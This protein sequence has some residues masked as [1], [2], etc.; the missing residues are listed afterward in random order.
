ME[1]IVVK[2]FIEPRLL[3]LLQ[4]QVELLKKANITRDDA[5]FHRKQV[6]NHPLLKVLHDQMA[7][8]A[9]EYFGEALKP[10]Y[11]FLSMYFEGQGACPLHVDRPQCY[12][13]IDV[14]LNQRRVWPIH[15]NHVDAWD[16][17][18]QDEIR[19]NGKGY[20]LEAGDAILYSGTDHPHWRIPMKDIEGQED[21][22]CDL[23][24]FHF[25]KE[26]FDGGLE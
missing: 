5:V 26:D 23:A 16:E 12:R 19:A 8:E 18:K 14:C 11:V 17:T 20:E 10:S 4:Y 25:V 9:S 24:F 15:I 6:H 2:N 7:V 13:T 21:N 3:K 22:F 1:P